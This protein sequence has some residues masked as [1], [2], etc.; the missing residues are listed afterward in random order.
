MAQEGC[1]VLEYVDDVLVV[2]ERLMALKLYNRLSDLFTELV[3]PM[4]MDT[5]NSSY[6]LLTCL[7]ICISI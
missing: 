4:N 2:A 5:K 3:L 7:G 6:K 1:K